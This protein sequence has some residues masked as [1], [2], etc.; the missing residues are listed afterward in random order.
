[1][2]FLLT[3]LLLLRFQKAADEQVDCTDGI[4]SPLTQRSDQ[5]FQVFVQMLKK[6]RCRISNWW[7]DDCRDGLQ[8]YKHRQDMSL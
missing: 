7:L 8:L 3:S 2:R 4:V 5:M 1:M 6:K